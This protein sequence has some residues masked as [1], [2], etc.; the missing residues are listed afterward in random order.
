MIVI[1]KPHYSPNF[2]LKYLSLSYYNNTCANVMD[3]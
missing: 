2:F 1:V 3:E